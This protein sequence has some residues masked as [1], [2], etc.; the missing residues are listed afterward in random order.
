MKKIKMNADE[1]EVYDN[2]PSEDKKMYSKMTH[3]ERKKY[4]M[5]SGKKAKEYM[6]ACTSKN[7]DYTGADFKKEMKS[8]VEDLDGD[9]SHGPSN[10]SM[11]ERKYF[12]K[13]CSQGFITEEEV[14]KHQKTCALT[15]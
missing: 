1:R 9:M 5:M 7:E 12:C 15:M 8:I 3:K 11:Q 6:F 10:E 4:S 2:L 13:Y 14:T